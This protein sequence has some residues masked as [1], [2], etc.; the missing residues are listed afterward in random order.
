M[1]QIQ[2]GT[3]PDFSSTNIIAIPG[4][5][6]SLH[7]VVPTKIVRDANEIPTHIEYYD[8]TT[9]N[10]ERISVSDLRGFFDIDPI[11]IDSPIDYPYDSYNYPYNNY[12]YNS[13]NYYS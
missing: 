6:Q 8:P 12:S 5:G 4:E 13:Y 3:M 10:G 11:I 7:F 1:H 2:G 9:G